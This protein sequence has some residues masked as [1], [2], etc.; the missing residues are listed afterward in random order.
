ML[1]IHCPK[2]MLRYPN[3]L[4]SVAEMRCHVVNQPLAF[5]LV[6]DLTEEDAHLSKVVLVAGVV[7]VHIAA[8]L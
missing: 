5:L 7:P 2:A 4:L 8:D 6:Q 1:I 3:E